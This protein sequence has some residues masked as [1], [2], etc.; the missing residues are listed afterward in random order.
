MPKIFSEP[1]VQLKLRLFESD[2][3][4]LR[5]VYKN[6]IGVNAAVRNIVRRYV[7]H[8]TERTTRLIDETEVPLDFEGETAGEGEND[9]EIHHPRA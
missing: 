4:I 2:V 1:V 9:S 5:S 8:L 6:D 7:R 3:A